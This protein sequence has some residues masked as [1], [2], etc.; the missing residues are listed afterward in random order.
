MVSEKVCLDILRALRGRTT[1]VVESGAETRDSLPAAT[2]RQLM[3][4][5][6]DKASVDTALAWLVDGGYMHASS[7]GFGP[8]MEYGLE[9]K[10][11]QVVDAEGFPDAEKALFYRADPYAVFIA[12]Q[13]RPEDEALIRY[14]REEVLVPDGFTPREGR[15]E[16]LEQFRTQ[17]LAKIEDSGLFLCL[18]THREALAGGGFV[19]SVWLY[20][21]IGAAMAYGREPLVLVEEGIGEHYSGQLQNI[22]EYV[23]FSRDNYQAVFQQEVVRRF[24]ADLDRRLIPRPRPA[25]R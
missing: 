24:H 6:Y 19:S 13:F 3:L 18:L 14:L 10:G 2:L 8:I 9:N 12:Q 1:R 11:R 17:I 22:Y 23:R 16:N 15:A 7:W 5:R 25:G 4:A 20:Q 21:E